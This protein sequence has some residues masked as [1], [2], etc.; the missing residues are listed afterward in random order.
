LARYF[1]KSRTVSKFST[2]STFFSVTCDAVRDWKKASL[3]FFSC[4][5]FFKS[6]SILVTSSVCLK[7]LCL[8]FE[9]S[10][11]LDGGSELFSVFI[12]FDLG[13][14]F[15]CTFGTET[16]SPF[17]IIEVFKTGSEDV[18]FGSDPFDDVSSNC[19]IKSLIFSLSYC[20]W[21]LLARCL[22]RH[23]WC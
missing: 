5:F 8:D 14:L 21:K 13:P 6:S 18:V 7:K 1:P 3:D 2:L 15:L 4:S 16:S 10:G 23:Y 20:Y 9:F 19:L 17:S 12:V 22:S 11:T